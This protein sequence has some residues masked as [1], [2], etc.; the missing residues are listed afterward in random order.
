[1]DDEAGAIYRERGLGGR[2]RAGR[3]PA[4]VVIDLNYA[5]TDPESPLGCDVD[6]AL[7]TIPALLSDA[8]AKRVPCIYT[9]IEYDDEGRR[10]AEVFLEKLP[11]LSILEKGSRWSRID[12]RVAPAPGEPI[13]GKLFASGFWGT[14]LDS[15]LKSCGCDSVILTGA[16]TS[17]CVRATAVDAMQHGYRVVVPRDAVADRARAPHEA[18]LFDIQAK[19]GEVVDTP[20][21]LGVLA[22]AEHPAGGMAS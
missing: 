12:D 9:T 17:G 4:L 22:L 5:F 14:E 11:A 16:S 20:T 3:S 18:A 19:Y 2:Q 7:A 1:M 6:L 13:L 15:V 8:R 21:A 10:A